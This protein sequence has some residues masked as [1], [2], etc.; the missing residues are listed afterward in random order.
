MTESRS[1]VGP[2]MR[3]QLRPWLKISERDVGRLRDETGH[4]R[5]TIQRWARGLEPV[6]ESTEKF[7]ELTRKKLGI[8]RIVKA[9]QSEVA[10]APTSVARVRKAA[11]VEPVQEPIPQSA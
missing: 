9:P 2:H 11:V 3:P 6:E 5:S 8:A 10:A 4:S 7:L 1:D